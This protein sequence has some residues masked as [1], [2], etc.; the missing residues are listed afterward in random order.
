MSK[1]QECAQG[2]D[3]IGLGL[4]REYRPG[5]ASWDRVFFRDKIKPDPKVTHRWKTSGGALRGAGY[6]QAWSYLLSSDALGRDVSLS[7]N[8]RIERPA[9]ISWDRN[10]GTSPFN[11]FGREENGGYDFGVLVRFEGPD[12]YYRV[13]VSHRWQEIVLWKSTGGNLRVVPA[14]VPAGRTI[15]LE[16]Q[17]AGNAIAVL[18]DGEPM[19]SYTDTHDPI[20]AGQCGVGVHES[21]VAFERICLQ[22]LAKVPPAGEGPAGHVPEFHVRDWHGQKW[23]FDGQ[24]PVFHF[25]MDQMVL[26]EAKVRP[27]WL[28]LVQG[29]MFWQHYLG[30]KGP[31]GTAAASQLEDFEIEESGQELRGRWSSYNK[32]KSLHSAE[33]LT[34]KYNAAK[35]LYEYHFDTEM[36]VQRG[37]DWDA[38][39]GLEF[40]DPIPYNACAM[41]APYAGGPPWHFRWLVY[42]A[43]DGTIMRRAMNHLWGPVRAYRKENGFVLMSSDLELSPIFRLTDA[44]EDE[45]IDA[46]FILCAWGY[47]LHLRLRVNDAPGGRIPGGTRLPVRF[48]FTG[49]EREETERLVEQSALETNEIFDPDKR[50]PI[51]VRGVNNFSPENSWSAAEPTCAQHWAGGTWDVETGYSDTYSMRLD[52]PGTVSAQIGPSAFSGP[53]ADVP[54]RLSAMVR[55]KDVEQKPFFRLE[56]LIASPRAPEKHKAKEEKHY[57]DLTGTNDWTRIEYVTEFP[58]PYIFNLRLEMGLEGKGTV[59]LDDFVFEPIVSLDD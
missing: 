50:Y 26:S 27:G 49:L 8:A 2:K 10:E 32:N 55:T 13:Q 17:V 37:F 11:Y 7:V 57:V 47:D 4:W 15:E 1:E 21:E 3:L 12:R 39:A 25:N 14:R 48:M 41:S 9:A 30:Y 40:F 22:G 58:N 51:Y 5:R 46:T 29:P 53:I 59:W 52:G 45:H 20:L 42:P 36:E 24:E 6:A 16:V 18:L 33:R 35:D 44:P 23:V 56:A 19:I 38:D 43:K 54:Y 28:P 34:L 31:A